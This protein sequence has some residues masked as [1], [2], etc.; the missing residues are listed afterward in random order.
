MTTIQQSRQHAKPPATHKP[1][2]ELT[3]TPSKGGPDQSWKDL[4]RDQRKHDVMT[5]KKSYISAHFSTSQKTTLQLGVH[6]NDNM[7]SSCVQ[8]KTVHL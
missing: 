1:P 2:V 8:V 6:H 4:L 3:M 5:D 7:K